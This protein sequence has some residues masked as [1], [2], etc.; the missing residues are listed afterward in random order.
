[1]NIIDHIGYNGPSIAIIITVVNL[2]DQTK[3]LVSF[4]LFYFVEYYLVGMMK[5][6]IKEPRPS[7]YLEKKYDDGGDY[8]GISLYGMPSGHS[9]AVWYAA[10][11]L[12]LVKGSPYLLILQLAICFNTMYQRWAFRKHS[13]A[14]LFA[15]ALVGGG[16][17]WFAFIVTK[18]AVR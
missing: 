1:M 7:G 6:M 11:F 14:Q 18:Q 8:E 15:G 9:S 4:I 16:V 13:V 2:L 12:W 3:Y 10:T 5:N 17:S